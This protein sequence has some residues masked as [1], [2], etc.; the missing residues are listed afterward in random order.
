MSSPL[1]LN[2]VHLLI[3][4][5][6]ALLGVPDLALDE[7]LICTLGLDDVALS[8]EVNEKEGTLMLYSVVAL[9]PDADRESFLI[10]ALSANLFW[11][12]TA[13]ATL[14][15]AAQSSAILLQRQMLL[16]SLDVQQ[17]AAC[18]EQFANQCEQWTAKLGGSAADDSSAPSADI[19]M[20]DFA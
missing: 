4:E 19:I 15:L 3:S 6:G 8:L 9:L 18:L 16:Q 5:L 20:H 1:D 7:S 10:A 12:E 13:G 11:A 2:P 14:A 17:L